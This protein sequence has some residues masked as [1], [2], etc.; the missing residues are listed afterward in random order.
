M[1]TCIWCGKPFRQAH[2]GRLTCRGP[3][4]RQHQVTVFRLRC[5][6]NTV[7]AKVLP[8]LVQRDHNRC[9]LCGKPV[10]ALT[11]SRGPSADHVIPLNHGGT[12]D[13]ENLQLAHLGCNKLKKDG[14]GGQGLLIG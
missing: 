3:C 9:G 10:R 8:Y 6:W 12:N 2:L 7:K 1:I 4:T 14:Y 11:G 13:L 5:D